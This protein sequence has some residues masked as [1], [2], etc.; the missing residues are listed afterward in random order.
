MGFASET[1]TVKYPVDILGSMSKSTAY[2]ILKRER[3]L[4]S[5]WGRRIAA[6]ERRGYFTNSMKDKAGNWFSCACGDM[7]KHIE[8]TSLGAPL[9]PI[10]LFA[11]QDFYYYVNHNE[12]VNAAGTLWA[13]EERSR[14]LAKV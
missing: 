3:L 10:L 4:N 8:R 13:I 9:D 7:D 2:D 6:A 12:F 14:E 11:G 1:G 5:K